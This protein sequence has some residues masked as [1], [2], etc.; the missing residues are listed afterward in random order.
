ML[1]DESLLNIDYLIF[2]SHKTA[3]QTLVGTFNSNGFNSRHCHTLK[4]SIKME[5]HFQDYL[6]A[7]LMKNK[8]KLTVISSFRE[9]IERHMSSF[10]Q[11]YGTKAIRNKEVKDKFE[12][13]LYRYSIEELCEQ[14]IHEL[15]NKSCS[16]MMN[17]S[18]MDII[19]E[20][21]INLNDLNYD[22]KNKFGLY[23]NNI[24]KLYIFDF[25]FITQNMS[26]ILTNIT[27]KEIIVKNSNTSED[28]WYKE[29]YHE[30][31]KTLVIPSQTIV[32]VYS[33]KSDLIKLFNEDDYDTILNNA[34]K[35][36]STIT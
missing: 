30:F 4:K 12:T 2:S 26:N 18:I 23:E 35:K 28:K 22:K 21:N 14:F 10:F 24:I 15:N 19:K 27:N 17:E 11:C 9:P 34:L 3:T 7:Y 32:D 5:G 25:K 36:Y 16:G 31:K 29:I 6:N 13:I 20:L 33:Y 1:F 8:R